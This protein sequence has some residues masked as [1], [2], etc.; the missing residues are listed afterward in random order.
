[1]LIQ[2]RPT[3]MRT[4]PAAAALL[5]AFALTG[6]AGNVS[7]AG[8]S[9]SPVPSSADVPS[10]SSPGSSSPGSRPPA[11]DRQKITGTVVEGV[12]PNCLVLRDST[13][14]HLL[15]FPDKSLRSV[16]KV[17]AKVTAVGRSEP[18]MMSTCQQGIPF[19]VSAVAAD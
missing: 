4:R 7:S 3:I 16:A 5:L 13:G 19:I 15:V 11:G 6:C 17:G 2:Q 14:S 8:S 9:A 18:K 10:S 1:M 12:E